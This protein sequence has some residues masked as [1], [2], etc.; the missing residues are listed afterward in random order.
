VQLALLTGALGVSGCVVL[1]RAALGGASSRGARRLPWLALVALCGFAGQVMLQPNWHT[2]GDAAESMTPIVVLGLAYVARE[3]G[4]LGESARRLF[5]VA[6]VAECVVFQALYL[7]WAFGPAWTRDP[8]TVLAARY[9]LTHLRSLSPM[10][11]PFGAL[12]LTAAALAAIVLLWRVLG[13][14]E[15]SM[16]APMAKPVTYGAAAGPGPAA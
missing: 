15:R 11:G 4:T 10:H 14:R 1:A 3:L 5:G 9:G 13:R 16:R 12:W 2:T 6:I 8:N 7:A